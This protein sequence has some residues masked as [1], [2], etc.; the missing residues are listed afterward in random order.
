[1]P[2]LPSATS[3]FG[4]PSPRALRP[5]STAALDSAR[6][7]FLHVADPGPAHLHGTQ[8]R[9]F[10]IAWCYLL[11]TFSSAIEALYTKV[12]MMTAFLMRSST[13]SVS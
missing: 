13:G 12:A 4:T 2:R 1:M 11:G 6:E 9:R 10:R 5:R 8:G 3:S 7:A